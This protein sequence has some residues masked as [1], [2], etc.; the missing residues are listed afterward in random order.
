MPGEAQRQF[1]FGAKGIGREPGVE[2]ADPQRGQAAHRMLDDAEQCRLQPDDFTR[3]QKI[4]DLP[5]AVAA[6]PE[7]IGPAGHDAK[8]TEADL[9]FADQHTVGR[10]RHLTHR[11]CFDQRPL[12]LAE[13]PEYVLRITI[14]S[15]AGHHNPPLLYQPGRLQIAENLAERKKVL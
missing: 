3:H 13:R 14:A 12:A 11:Q 7:A 6:A 1:G 4:E 5:A 8:Q 2:C 15:P 10:Q 9:A